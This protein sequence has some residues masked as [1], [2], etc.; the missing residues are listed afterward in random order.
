MN[1]LVTGNAGFIGSHLTK[2]LLDQ[3]HTVI[4][5][6]NF[7]LGTKENM[8]AYVNHPNFKFVEV[9]IAE[10]DILIKEV[11]SLGVKI[12]KIY[13]LAA[14]SDIQKG[15][16]N[17]LIDHHDTFATTFG[18]LELAR[19]LD[20]KN[21]FFASTSAVYGDLTD[22][23][24]KEDQ[25][26]LSPISY[27]GASKLASEAFISAYTYM[28]DMN[29]VIFR[30]PNVVGPNLTHGVIFDFKKKLEKNNAELE[31][32]GDGTQRKQYTHVYDLV[33]AILLLTENINPGAEIYNVGVSDD[34]SVKDIA[35]ILCQQMGLNDVIYNYTGGNVGW[36]GDVPKFKYNTDKINAKGWHPK[37]SSTEAITETIRW[38]LNK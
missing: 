28:I 17:P 22:I 15:G 20:V 18:V 30:F 36:K 2:S 3:G 32:L 19:A 11:A 13:H 21:L 7:T 12:E 25:G 10:V 38:E 24:L 34:T 8:A 23:E 4:G 33:E 31:I 16:T 26:G 27:Y 9:D 35:D 14:N 1:V 37:Y 29:T 6:D 5:V